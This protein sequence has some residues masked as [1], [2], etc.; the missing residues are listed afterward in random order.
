MVASAAGTRAPLTRQVRPEPA[1]TQ[2]VGPER[3][4]EPELSGAGVRCLPA[5]AASSAAAR[6]PPRRPPAGPREGARRRLHPPPPAP[7]A[8]PS[9]CVSRATWQWGGSADV[10]RLP[11]RQA[12]GGRARAAVGDSRV[13]PRSGTS[14]GS[15]YSSEGSPP[16]QLP[17]SQQAGKGLELEMR[18][19]GLLPRAAGGVSSACICQH[20]PW[21]RAH[22]HYR[23]LCPPWNPWI[24]SPPGLLVGLAPFIYPLVKGAQWGLLQEEGLQ[25]PSPSSP[26][27]A[28]PGTTAQEVPGPA[29]DP[30][31]HQP[32]SRPA[33]SSPQD[34]PKQW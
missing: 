5:P 15:G 1:G 17:H 19:R 23:L 13:Q 34:W 10:G 20:S 24:S 33:G 16:I 9:S 8:P 27:L 14:E 12:P 21:R 4:P 31:K 26:A 25:P 18:S 28:G 6:S 11:R 30:T 32:L 2:R 29:G 22:L 3:G 7:R